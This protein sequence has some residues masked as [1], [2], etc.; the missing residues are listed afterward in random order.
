MFGLTYGWLDL[1][2]RHHVGAHLTLSLLGPGQE[3]GEALG[4]AGDRHHVAVGDHGVQ[5]GAARLGRVPGQVLGISAE[6]K[7]SE[8]LNCQ[9]PAGESI[10]M[11]PL[12]RCGVFREISNNKL[13]P[14][15]SLTL[16]IIQ[17]DLAS[18]KSKRYYCDFRGILNALTRYSNV[19]TFQYVDFILKWEGIWA[20]ICIW[21]WTCILGKVF[22]LKSLH[23]SVHYIS[24]KWI[25]NSI[26]KPVEISMPPRWKFQMKL[27]YNSYPANGY[28]FQ[29]T[30]V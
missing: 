30:F 25:T 1:V 28:T 16:Q 19:S 20:H 12:W 2:H 17:L 24:W 5:A 26:W 18:I 22:L 8:C 3:G 6:N 11:G 21:K 9:E 7:G 15:Q 29:G 27:G 13:N 23:L 14:R 4:H 10:W